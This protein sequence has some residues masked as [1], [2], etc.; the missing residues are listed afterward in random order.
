MRYHLFKTSRTRNMISGES[1]AKKLNIASFNI[2]S[3]RGDQV[4]HVYKFIRKKDIYDTIVL[5]IGGKDLFSGE[6]QS[7]FSASEL[8][9]GISDLANLLLTRAKRVFV[10]GIP[11]R[12]YQPERRKE[13]N[14]SLASWRESWKFRGISRHVY[15]DIHLRKD[16]VHLS[17]DALNGNI[18]ILKGKI[19]YNC[20][21]P[22][23]ELEGH[24][25]AFEC[26]G[27]CKCLS[28]TGED[29]DW[30]S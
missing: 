27:V 3:L 12:Q 18:F 2:L 6:A 30:L 11:H 16:K 26:C 9:Q 13:V 22:E 20:Y 21:R 28:W 1:Q 15:S 14:A 8:V 24:P 10:L 7:S 5:F 29:Y 25:K 19:L 17:S 4:K 23:L